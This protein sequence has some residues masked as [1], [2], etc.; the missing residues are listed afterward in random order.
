MAM[1]VAY[2]AKVYFLHT[3]ESFVQNMHSVTSRQFFKVR[4][5]LNL[6]KYI[7]VLE[8]VI[9][10][11]KDNSKVTSP[12]K[13]VHFSLFRK[14]FAL[15]LESWYFLLFDKIFALLRSL[16]FPE[17]ATVA[18]ALKSATSDGATD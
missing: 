3:F 1:T 11:T 6:S 15:L 8:Y 9:L 14:R 5:S 16:Q 4:C 12:I 17:E 10:S 2:F 18:V 13:S 7:M